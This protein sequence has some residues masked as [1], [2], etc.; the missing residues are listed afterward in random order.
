VGKSPEEI[1]EE[2]QKKALQFQILQSSLQIIH[3]K[4]H[5][6]MQRLEEM[7]S[8][9]HAMEDVKSVKAGSDVLVPLGSGNFIAGKISGTEKVLVGVGGG[10]AIKKSVDGALESLNSRMK[11]MESA[12]LEL[13]NQAAHIGD[14][15]RMIQSEMK[16]G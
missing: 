6:L 1:K 9:R 7:D 8:T 4:E 10:I 2:M 12:L 11:E 16:M 15:L 3:E 14:E 5:M 13:R